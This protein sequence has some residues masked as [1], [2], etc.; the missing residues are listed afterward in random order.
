M[1]NII[2]LILLIIN[3][4]LNAQELNVE[5][6]KLVINN[7]LSEW[8]NSFENFNWDEF[9]EVDSIAIFESV[10]KNKFKNLK[11][12][13][14]IY[15]PIIS[16]SKS[17]DKFIDIYSYQLNL[18]KKN[19]KYYSTIDVGQAIF[20]C[21]IKNNYWTRIMY[22]EY[23]GIIDDVV[24]RDE[25]SFLLVGT[26]RNENDKNTPVIYFGNLKN[27]SFSIIMSTNDECIQKEEGFKS[28]KLN[29]II[30]EEN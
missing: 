12:F 18:E 2:F 28:E 7:N 13:Q 29:N 21:D 3:L 16:Y 15:D 27:K 20:L 22:L 26:Q 30:I 5:N 9:V 11:Q 10:V 24:W 14:S 4:N 6:A 17:N 8:P 25:N 1:K 19:E 23:S